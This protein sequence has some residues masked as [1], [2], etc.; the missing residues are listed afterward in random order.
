ME[1]KYD[2]Y[3]FSKLIKEIECM[4]KEIYSKM[5]EKDTKVQPHPHINK[6]YIHDHMRANR[7]KILELEKKILLRNK[8]N[9]L[10]EESND[11]DEMNNEKMNNE[12]FGNVKDKLLQFLYWKVSLIYSWFHVNDSLELVKALRDKIDV[13]KLHNLD[14]SGKKIENVRDIVIKLKRFFIENKEKI[15]IL[16]YEKKLHANRILEL[17]RQLKQYNF[18]YVNIVE[19]ETILMNLKNSVKN[20]IYFKQPEKSE[21]IE[22]DQEINEPRKVLKFK[23]IFRNNESGK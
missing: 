9:K 11:D 23:S 1:V 3:D 6:A 14:I 10:N 16:S 13:Q 7:L 22:S 17:E 12:L 21:K 8:S 4:R 20:N 15:S 18:T 19:L 5:K 2:M